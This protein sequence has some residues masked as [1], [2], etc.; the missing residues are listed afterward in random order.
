MITDV[1]REMRVAARAENRRA[2]GDLNYWHINCAGITWKCAEIKYLDA[3]RDWFTQKLAK[4]TTGVNTLGT[5]LV[6][7]NKRGLVQ[8]LVVEVALQQ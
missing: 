6:S 5:E 8:N 7:S 4:E 2:L 1:L 3:I